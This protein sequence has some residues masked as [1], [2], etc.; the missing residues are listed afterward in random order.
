MDEFWQWIEHRTATEA[1]EPS[2]P[3]TLHQASPASGPSVSVADPTVDAK[4]SPAA[5]TLPSA[6]WLEVD[7]EFLDEDEG[8][9][10]DLMAIVNALIKATKKHKSFGS[11]FKLEAVKA[12]LELRGKY[13][14][15]P[16]VLNPRTRASVSCDLGGTWPLFRT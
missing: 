14:R 1:A 2:A 16:K 8:E 5:D 3:A 6:A 4:T 7:D 10:I 13:E 9:H 12:Y 11:T 15:N